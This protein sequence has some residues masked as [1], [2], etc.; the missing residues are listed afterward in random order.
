MAES[1]NTKK[2]KYAVMARLTTWTAAERA[3]RIVMYLVVIYLIMRLF[4]I[5]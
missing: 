1:L 2:G 3:L 5:I 4:K